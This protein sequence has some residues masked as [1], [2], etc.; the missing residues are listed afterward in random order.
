[1]FGVVPRHLRLANLHE[2]LHAVVG[3]VLG[4]I[5]VLLQHVEEAEFLAVVR[6]HDNLALLYLHGGVN[7]AKQ[8][9]V[10]L[11]QL[12]LLQHAA[13]HVG[14]VV[15]LVEHTHTHFKPLFY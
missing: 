12:E 3:I 13:H 11:A 15:L 2:D 14:Q 7:K 4:A 10:P 1:M 5:I 6:L 8:C 9:L